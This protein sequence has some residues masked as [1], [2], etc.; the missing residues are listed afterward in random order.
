MERRIRDMLHAAGSS[1]EYIM[2]R[3]VE[4]SIH[5]GSVQEVQQKG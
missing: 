5:N 1:D 4:V 3:M 2:S